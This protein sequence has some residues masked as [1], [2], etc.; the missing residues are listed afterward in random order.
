MRISEQ[1]DAMEVMGINSKN[2]LILPKIGAA[3]TM[4]PMLIAISIFLGILGGR[5]AGD[6]TGYVSNFDFDKGLV[7]N[8]KFYN[9]SF[10][11]AKSYTFAFIVSAIPAYFGFN[12]KG[13]ALEIGKAGTT[14]VVTSCILI[15]FADYTL[16]TILLKSN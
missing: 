1:I 8:W 12:V 5:I 4:I 14:S 13:G 7:E 16:A 11:F 10:A 15:L 3:L 6:F 2:F 9:L